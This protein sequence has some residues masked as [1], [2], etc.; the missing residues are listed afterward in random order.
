[1]ISDVVTTGT[2]DS[3]VLKRIRRLLST[4]VG[5]VPFDRAFG[6]DLSSIDSAPAALEGAVMV[7]YSRAMLEYF[8]DYT[9]SDISFAV[10]CNQ[11][12]P[13]VVISSV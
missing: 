10:D 11:I 3:A 9:I 5:T 12:T 7:A 8:P 2:V 13:T 4:P 6:V 1:M